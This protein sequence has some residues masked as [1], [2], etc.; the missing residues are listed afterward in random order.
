MMNKLTRELKELGDNVLGN[1]IQCGECGSVCPV[2]RVSPDVSPRKALCRLALDESRSQDR[3]ELWL[4]LTCYACDEVCPQGI[5][6]VDTLLLVR[7]HICRRG[8][9][10]DTVREMD[11]SLRKHGTAVPHTAESRKLREELGL[12]ELVHVNTRDMQKIMC[13]LKNG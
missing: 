9:I 4:C 5:E 8:E 6:L 2:G 12:E 1:C 11:K 13:F 10:P 3:E 7:N